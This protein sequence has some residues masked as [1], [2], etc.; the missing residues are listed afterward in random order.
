MQSS[1]ALF[2]SPFHHKKRKSASPTQF[3]LVD[4][5]D[6]ST[7]TTT[8]SSS[9]SSS[10]DQGRE[11]HEQA[12]N[13]LTTLKHHHS[14][15]TIQ[16]RC[17]EC[18]GGST[19]TTKPTTTGLEEEDLFGLTLTTPDLLLKEESE[20]PMADVCDDVVCGEAEFQN[21]AERRAA[22]VGFVAQHAE[23]K[24]KQL[25]KFI[26]S[27]VSLRKCDDNL[28]H[29]T[30][31]EDY[32]CLCCSAH[33]RAQIHHHVSTLPHFLVLCVGRWSGTSSSSSSHQQQQQR[34][35]N[36]GVLTEEVICVEGC[37]FSLVGTIH[38]IGTSL[39]SGHYVCFARSFSVSTSP[40]SQVCVQS[41]PSSSPFHQSSVIE[42]IH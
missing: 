23:L 16:T 41:Y 14:T 27:P 19:P 4:E 12:Q 35:N 40:S 29:T 10:K 2:G 13:K 18:G 7:T 22:F 8:T 17:F 36:T 34:K 25:C 3:K 5:V 42:I 37:S 26:K 39:R 11:T 21:D 1:A 28:N 30:T 9:S 31:L 24:D 38:H 15:T 33:H 20:V 6:I 32:D